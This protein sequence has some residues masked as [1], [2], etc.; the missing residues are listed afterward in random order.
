LLPLYIP[1]RTPDRGLEI[2]LPAISWRR[3]RRDGL[4]KQQQQRQIVCMV[5]LMAFLV[6]SAMHA[7]PAEAGI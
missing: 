5:F 2:H 7:V 3:D 4:A 6:I 1:Q